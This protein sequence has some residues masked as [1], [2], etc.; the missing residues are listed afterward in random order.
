M[1]FFSSHFLH[2]EYNNIVYAKE[3]NMKSK[4]LLVCKSITYA[5]KIMNILNKNGYYAGISRTPSS[6]K[7]KS[8]SYSVTIYEKDLDA[9]KGLLIGNVPTV[10][11]YLVSNNFYSYLGVLE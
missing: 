3:D 2:I 5:Q 8:C 6:I 10:Q 9:I 11:I 4:C 1:V 7:L